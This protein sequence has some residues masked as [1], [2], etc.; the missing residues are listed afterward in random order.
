MSK[1]PSLTPC[2]GYKHKIRHPCSIATTPPLPGFRPPDS[3]IAFTT[4]DPHAQRIAN[5]FAHQGRK[6]TTDVCAGAGLVCSSLYLEIMRQ[7]IKS[8]GRDTVPPPPSASEARLSHIDQLAWIRVKYEPRSI[9]TQI[10]A[11]TAALEQALMQLE[12]RDDSTK[13]GVRAHVMDFLRFVWANQGDFQDWALQWL[14]PI[15]TPP[16]AEGEEVVVPNFLKNMPSF[17]VLAKKMIPSIV[18]RFSGTRKGATS[19][20]VGQS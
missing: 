15:Y 2:L 17:A 11:T 3:G 1:V 7:T 6:I 5:W 13:H 19:A 20:C 8:E 14:F 9:S 4:H 10:Y 18:Y 16:P 12:A